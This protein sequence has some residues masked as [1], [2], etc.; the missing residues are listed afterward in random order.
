MAECQFIRRKEPSKKPDQYP[1]PNSSTTN[2]ESEESESEE[3]T[4]SSEPSDSRK[5]TSTGPQ[6]Q[7]L[8]KPEFWTSSTTP[9]T[10]SLS[11]QKL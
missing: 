9:P 3:A 10:T 11:E 7:S 1:T 8:E 4:I 5:E 2:Q 6:N